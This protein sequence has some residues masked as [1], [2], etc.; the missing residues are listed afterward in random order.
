MRPDADPTVAL[1]KAL[2]GLLRWG[3]LLAA[4]VC[5][6][7]GIHYLV[8]HGGE[9]V[10]VRVFVGEPAELRSVR[11]VLTWAEENRARGTIQLGLLL[12]V[13]VPVVRVAFSAWSFL[14]ER[15]WIF[16]G[17]TL[18]VLAGL[19]FSLLVER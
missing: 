3:V 11:G 9:P 4:A 17:V 6:F 1:E 13:A 16:A 2:A 18:A 12:L 7:G 10:Q 5:L 15:D 14:R 19:L 8:N